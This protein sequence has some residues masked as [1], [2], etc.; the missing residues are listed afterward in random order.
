MKLRN[1]DKFHE[2]KKIKSPIVNKAGN[3]KTI[4]NNKVCMHSCHALHVYLQYILKL[5]FY[6]ITLLT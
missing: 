6:T 3:S 1:V 4:F 2:S 5:L